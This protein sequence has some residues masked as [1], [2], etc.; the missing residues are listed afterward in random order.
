M[1]HHLVSFIF[2][3]EY[4]SL[5]VDAEDAREAEKK[6]VINPFIS[7]ATI[8]IFQFREEGYKRTRCCYGMGR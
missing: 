2:P 1:N 3:Q 5:C 7:R 4:L 6:S 8:F